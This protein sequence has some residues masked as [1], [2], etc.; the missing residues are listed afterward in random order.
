MA[1]PLEEDCHGGARFRGLCLL[2]APPMPCDWTGK[3]RNEAVCH[4]VFVGSAVDSAALSLTGWRCIQ[5]AKKTIVT[6]IMP[7][8]IVT[9]L[10]L[11]R[12]GFSALIERSP[13]GECLLVRITLLAL[14]LGAI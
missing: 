6:S 7:R 5:T 1:L 10:A 9:F 14:A 13:G 4:R 2:M 8:R 11:R 3:R 12:R